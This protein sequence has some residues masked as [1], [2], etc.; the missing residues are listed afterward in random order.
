M[1]S[2]RE[3][4]FWNR[5]T[6][7]V[8]VEKV[9]GD[10]WLKRG[11]NHPVGRLLT[12]SLLSSRPFSQ[13]YGGLQDSRWS[14]RKVEPFIRDFKIDMSEYQD[15]PFANF[16]QFFIRRFRAGKRPVI[17]APHLMA[18]PAEARYLGF[19]K[20]TEE[21]KFPVKGT[22]LSAA[23]LLGDSEVAKPFVGGPLLLAR[24]CPVDYHRYHFPDDGRILRAWTIHGPYHSVNPVALRARPDIFITNERQAALLETK[25][26]GRLAYIEVGALCVGKIVQSH[27]PAK[28]FR[29]GDEKGYF[30][31]GG[32]TVI[33]LGEPGAWKPSVDLLENTR[34]DRETLVRLGEEI[35]VKG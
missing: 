28:P 21:Q 29:R 26:F 15:G 25:N 18:A 6:R 13:L 5:H 24:L 9:Y 3:I 34:Q 1:A 7:Q 20:I 19:E 11:Y 4:Q 12:N 22:F 23:G 8:E 27:D 16:N 10:A 31:F 33:V 2:A 14:A 32:S 17:Q 35:A 30:L